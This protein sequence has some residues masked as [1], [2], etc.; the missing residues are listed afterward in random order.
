MS[1]N[2]GG[3]RQNHFHVAKLLASNG[4]FVDYEGSGYWD[5][6][7]IEVLFFI[8]RCACV[9]A[10]TCVLVGCRVERQFVPAHITIQK[11]DDEGQTFSMLQL[12]C[13]ILLKP[14][15]FLAA[16]KS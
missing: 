8:D 15:L 5:F 2:G 1:L 12:Y 6:R 14:H 7:V 9:H 11:E 4:F 16:Y 13:I 3:D 10:H